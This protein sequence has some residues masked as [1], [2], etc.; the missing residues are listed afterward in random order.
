MLGLGRYYDLPLLPVV[1]FVSAKIVNSMRTRSE[2]LVSLV[3]RRRTYYLLESSKEI[4]MVVV[5]MYLKNP[6]PI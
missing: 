4:D 3:V 5:Y 1:V 6:N 2:E